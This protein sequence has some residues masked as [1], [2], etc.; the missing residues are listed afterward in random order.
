MNDEHV[1]AF[2]EAIDRA[3]LDAIHVFAADTGVDNDISHGREA[4]SEDFCRGEMAR[5][6]GPV[7]AASCTVCLA[8]RSAAGF[9]AL[10]GPGAGHIVDIE[11]RGDMADEGVFLIRAFAVRE[12]HPVQPLDHRYP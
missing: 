4:S 12:S 6:G 7:N 10:A 5:P 8:L 11:Q 3:N 9:C 1:L 2:I